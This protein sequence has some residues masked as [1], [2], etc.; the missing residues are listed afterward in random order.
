MQEIKEWQEKGEK[1]TTTKKERW[2]E[3]GHQL[4]KRLRKWK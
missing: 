1:V 2:P 4:I 3:W